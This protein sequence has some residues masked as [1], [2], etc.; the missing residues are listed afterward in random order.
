M[1]I[2]EAVSSILTDQECFEVRELDSVI[3]KGRTSPLRVYEVHD[4]EPDPDQ[5]QRKAEQADSYAQALTAFRAGQLQQAKVSFS[6]LGSARVARQMWIER[7]ERL[8]EVG[9]PAD[10][11]GVVR[12]TVK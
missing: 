3:V 10:W 5:R 8:I 2:S 7:C 4:G 9:L 1:V 11:D 12:M 6:Q